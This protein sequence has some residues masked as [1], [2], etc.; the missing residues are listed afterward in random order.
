[1][2]QAKKKKETKSFRKWLKRRAAIEPL[3][4]HMKNDGGA[5]RNHLLGKQGDQINALMMGIGFNMRKILKSFPSNFFE[6]LFYR[7]F[8]LNQSNSAWFQLEVVK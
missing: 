2:D 6:L 5:K 3:I 8:A 7:F 4:G 1:M